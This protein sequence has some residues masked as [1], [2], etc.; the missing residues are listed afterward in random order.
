M[1]DISSTIPG[2]AVINAL[3]HHIE[4]RTPKLHDKLAKMYAFPGIPKDQYDKLAAKE[5]KRFEGNIV[6][7]DG[8]QDSLIYYKD[9]KA[10]RMAEHELM[11]APK[12]KKE[13]K[14][15]S[16]FWDIKHSTCADHSE[17]NKQRAPLWG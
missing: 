17:V 5:K 9:I 13:L 1:N 10:I 15:V 4:E 12:L 16:E 3:I 6:I 2:H 7:V 14:E 11:M 8:A